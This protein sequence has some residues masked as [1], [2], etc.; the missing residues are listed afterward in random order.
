MYYSSGTNGGRDASDNLYDSVVCRCCRSFL[1]SIDGAFGRRLPFASS[2]LAFVA[3][4][5][6]WL[7]LV[8][9]FLVRRRPLFFCPNQIPPGLVRRSPR[10]PTAARSARR[11]PQKKRPFARPAHH[12]PWAID[13]FLTGGASENASLNS[14]YIVF[15]QAR[16]CYWLCLA[17]PRSLGIQYSRRES[18]AVRYK[19]HGEVSPPL[20]GAFLE[21]L[22]DFSSAA[23]ERTSERTS[24]LSV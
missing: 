21:P 2:F 11:A 8:D 1:Q 18:L 23:A 17:S 5:L 4:F 15:L 7:S 24:V 13:R 22:L 10:A 12:P 9:L 16:V 19:R 20:E 6:A 3:C 14:Y